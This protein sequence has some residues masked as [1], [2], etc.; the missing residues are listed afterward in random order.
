MLVLGFGAFVAQQ[1][2]ESH[3]FEWRLLFLIPAFILIALCL[4]VIVREDISSALVDHR[5]VFTLFF[6]LYFLLGASV[7]TFEQDDPAKF[8][9]TGLPI[10]EQ[11]VLLIDAINLIGFGIALGVSLVVRPVYLLDFLERLTQTF[12]RRLGL[13]PLLF[14]GS[15]IC[16]GFI[17]KFYIFLTVLNESS[18]PVAGAL[19]YLALALP[20]GIF[21]TI[22]TAD[23]IRLKTM[24]WLAGL[25]FA[26]SLIGVMLFSKLDIIA[27]ICAVFFAYVLRNKSMFTAVLTIVVCIQLLSELGGP[28]QFS[29]D[30][31]LELGGAS[32]LVRIEIFVDGLIAANDTF[33]TRMN[34]VYG[35]NT[36]DYFLGARFSFTEPQIA[37]IQLYE[38]GYSS[39]DWLLLPWTFV[40]RI[41]NEAKPVMSLAGQTLFNL[42]INRTGSSVS[43][44]IFV[45]GFYNGGWVGMFVFSA[46]SGWILAYTSAVSKVIYFKK[47]FL[48]Y[49]VLAIG[50]YIAF[51]VDGF[52]LNDYVSPFVALLYLLVG[53]R[54]ASW[55][56]DAMS[57]VGRTKS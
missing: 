55:L 48:L 26:S 42:M 39:S 38:H 53:L 40:P 20:F 18:D 6:C 47:C 25:V 45:D 16:I 11:L 28:I 27:P 35:E 23:E 54:V 41:F 37:A 49:P 12:N 13:S 46:V 31:L 36:T 44:G 2:V 9:V 51:K 21:L 22:L 29:R 17:A 34:G 14:A 50:L 30:R 24:C 5:V 43:V 15:L 33:T 19:H 57:S 1:I 32:A 3:Q 8:N 52:W 4:F 56:L 7:A 10:N